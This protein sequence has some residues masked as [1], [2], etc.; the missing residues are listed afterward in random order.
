MH[1]S[2]PLAPGGVQTI[3]FLPP[4]APPAPPPPPTPA[5]ETQTPFDTPFDDGPF[6][7]DTATPLY[8]AA[9]PRTSE[10]SVEITAALHEFLANLPY[11]DALEQTF[12]MLASAES[13]LRPNSL[14]SQPSS[15]GSTDNGL[16]TVHGVTRR[17]LYAFCKNS[18]LL[19]SSR[20][21]FGK[22]HSALRLAEVLQKHLDA[23]TSGGAKTYDQ[24]TKS[25]SRALKPTINPSRPRQTAAAKEASFFFGAAP[26]SIFLC[27]LALLR[28]GVSSSG[29][30]RTFLTTFAVESSAALLHRSLVVMQMR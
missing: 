22:L 21:S 4:T 18:S 17:T 27:K 6:G 1:L 15:F 11:R 8:A 2:N 16:S 5:S 25:F 7:S 19:Q 12:S 14:P 24:P 3:M 29:D 9:P 20:V 26:F 10:K 28:S 30:L 23:A 13:N